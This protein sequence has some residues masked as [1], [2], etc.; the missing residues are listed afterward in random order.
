MSSPS[1]QLLSGDPTTWG[2]P[3]IGSTL[4]GI[5]LSNQLVLVNN[6]GS[7]A[8]VITPVVSAAPADLSFANAGITT[9]ITPSAGQSTAVGLITGAARNCPIVLATAGMVNGMILDVTL[10][11][12][13]L[14][15]LIMNFYNTIGSGS[16]LY[17]VQS[18]TAGGITTSWTRFEFQS[19]SGLWVV[20]ANKTPAY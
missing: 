1:F 15:N 17:V 4:M 10:V 18:S 9:T 14:D 20:L 8:A 5:N 6:N 7:G 19:A 2:V 11:F 12:P 3:P 16:P 13:A